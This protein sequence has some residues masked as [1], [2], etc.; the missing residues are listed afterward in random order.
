MLIVEVGV[1]SVTLELDGA[2]INVVG[3]AALVSEV[4]EATAFD[5]EI[6][7]VFLKLTAVLEAVSEPP[8]ALMSE[9]EVVCVVLRLARLSFAN[10]WVVDATLETVELPSLDVEEIRLLSELAAAP[11]VSMRVFDGNSTTARVLRLE[12]VADLRRVLTIDVDIFDVAS[13]LIGALEY[14]VGGTDVITE[15]LEMLG[16]S[17]LLVNEVF[18]LAGVLEVINVS[19]ELTLEAFAALEIDALLL[20]VATELRGELD[21]S[22][23]SA[24]VLWELL[25][26]GKGKLWLDPVV[27]ELERLPE[28]VA[29]ELVFA[30]GNVD[31]LK[32]DTSLKAS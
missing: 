4:A 14:D 5:V 2:L 7:D 12:V 15:L 22:N 19:V 25:E 17:S 23:P 27:V 8:S 3:D 10:V 30:R 1:V 13:E 21:P 18:E 26:L 11:V 9:V 32:H 28:A 24:V 31:S 29:A 16:R 6:L 20:D